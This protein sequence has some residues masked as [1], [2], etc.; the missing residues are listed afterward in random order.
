MA[1]EPCLKFRKKEMKAHNF[2]LR[3]HVP[4]RLQPVGVAEAKRLFRLMGV[5]AGTS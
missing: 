5:T 2:C 3:E 1:E 4:L